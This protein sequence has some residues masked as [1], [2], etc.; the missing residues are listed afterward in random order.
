[1]NGRLVVTVP[2]PETVLY[3]EGKDRADLDALR[4]VAEA[5]AKG[6]RRRISTQLFRWVPS[7]WELV[8]P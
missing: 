6:D 7:G 1:M 3:I 4:R 2:L 8:N 5:T